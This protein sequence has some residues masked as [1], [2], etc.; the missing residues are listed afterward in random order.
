[1][2]CVAAARPSAGGGKRAREQLRRALVRPE[3]DRRVGQPVHDRHAVAA[4]QARARPPA[5]SPARRGGVYL[6]YLY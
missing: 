3:V 2:S 1:M 4:P 5:V 6:C